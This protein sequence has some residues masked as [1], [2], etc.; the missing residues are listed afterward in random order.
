MA[1]PY[2]P[3]ARRR[4]GAATPSCPPSMWWSWAA[5][6]WPWMPP[7]A[8]ALRRR[9]DHRVP[10]GPGGAPARAEEVSTL[11][12]RGI[13][14]R[15]LTNPVGDRGMKNGLC[16]RIRCDTM[17]LGEPD[18]TAAAAPRWCQTITLDCDAVIMAIR[19]TPE[20]LLHRTTAG[21]AADR[22]G[23]ADHRGGQLPHPPCRAFF[24][25]G[26]SDRS[27]HRHLAMG[28]AERRRGN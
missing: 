10:A 27:G 7:D 15:P 11:R 6:M 25:G 1:D 19:T 4:T 3:D 5:A 20:S 21:L 17:A 28:L 2:Q 23:A 14:F 8:P 24:A 9:G 13:T 12:R 16:D 22:R 18:E 26:R